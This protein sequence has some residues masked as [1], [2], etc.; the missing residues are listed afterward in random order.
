MGVC[1][2]KNIEQ[3]FIDS[4]ERQRKD[5]LDKVLVSEL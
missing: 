1:E 3:P 4:I 2:T 5:L